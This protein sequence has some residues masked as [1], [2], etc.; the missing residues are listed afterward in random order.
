MGWFGESEFK[1][2]DKV[3]VPVIDLEGTI[4]DITLQVILVWLKFMA[5]I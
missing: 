3:L 1:V 2:G 4:I 5:I